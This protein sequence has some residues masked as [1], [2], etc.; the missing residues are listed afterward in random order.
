MKGRIKSRTE[1]TQ[2]KYILS[3]VV[4]LAMGCGQDVEQGPSGIEIEALD[5]SADPCVDF[6][7]FACGGWIQSHSINAQASYV[8]K[9]YDPYYKAL[10]QLQKI[11]EDAAAGVRAADDPHAALIGGYYASCLAAPGDTSHR[12]TLRALLTKIDAVTTLDDLARQVAAQ[13]DVGSGSF[14][15]FYVS[16][17]PGDATSYV[18]VLDQG[19]F[20]LADRSYYLDADQQVVLSRY[21]TH[22]QA[23]SA[24]IGGTPIDAPAA[25]RVETAIA[26]ATLPREEWRDPESL[27]HPMPAAEAAALAPTFP[28]QVF[29]DE[30]G[31]TT[32]Q[33]INV[34]VPDYLTALDDLFKNTPIDDLKSYLRWQL[35]QDYASNLDQ[36]FL[37]EDFHFWSTF[38]GQT[39]AAPRWFTCFNTTL[40]ALGEAIARPYVARHF[41]EKA[42]E[43]T[44]AMFDRARTAF[45]KRLRSA[46]WLDA[47]TR[48][49]ALAKL[50]EI[51]AKIGYPA[52]S[53]D[54]TGLV[55]QPDSF[56]DNHL[57]LRRFWQ[58][59]NRARLGQAVDR[60]EWYASPMTVNAFYAATSND[61]TLPAALLTSPF[62]DASRIDAANFGALGA[63]I[64]HEMTH[65]FDDQGRH[66]DGHGTLRDWWTP[67][68]EARFVERSQCIVDQ[69]D[70]YEPLPGEH[71][72]GA[73]TLGE[74][75][76]DLG[77][78]N[79]AYAALF[80]GR[81]EEE[82]GGDG[83]EAAQ[84][85]FL[86]YAQ[87]WCENMRPDLR[88]QRLL[89]DPHAPG[90]FRV[91]GVLSN[92]PEFRE[93]FSCPAD[94]PMARD[95]AC[96][97]W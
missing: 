40:N 20:E 72:N 47:P 78:V 13:R 70:A 7:Q 26:R 21:Q 86:S 80:D 29:W 65:G 75:I 43:S 54:F 18:A 55:L 51:V 3:F 58:A 66:F 67:T 93:A 36:A 48:A 53:P 50:D 17:D 11:V 81:E 31:F 14:F 57:N 44:K 90:R 76:A 73:L 89:T 42:S 59:R 49:E 97:V 22:I 63:V 83:F 39:K 9:F 96:E 16:A 61:L 91:N 10:P 68:V 62:F 33:N 88:S 92:L 37:D 38:T 30:A 28:W 85:F 4:L 79:I 95:E 82:G 74:N 24:L 60:A 34:T 94:G 12:D 15:H 1:E 64:G 6:Y 23:M 27:Y 5:Q 87:T 46:A 69:F 32:L 25:I 84:I 77:G 45:A 8:A 56:I 41:D 52:A 71:V 2:M 35:L 19:G